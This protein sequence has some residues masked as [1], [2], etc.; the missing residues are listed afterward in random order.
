M[1]RFL[2]AAALRLFPFLEDLAGLSLGAKA[3]FACLTLG[4]DVVSLSA[5]NLLRD[6]CVANSR[7]KA[8]KWICPLCHA[9]VAATPLAD[10]TRVAISRTKSSKIFYRLKILSTTSGKYQS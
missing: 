7:R 5:V 2:I 1:I 4:L 3:N 6:R 8:M 9:E 10:A